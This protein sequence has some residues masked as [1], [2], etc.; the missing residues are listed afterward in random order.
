[1]DDLHGR[2]K[3]KVGKSMDIIPF[4]GQLKLKLK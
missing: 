3:H 2:S 4:K 1:M